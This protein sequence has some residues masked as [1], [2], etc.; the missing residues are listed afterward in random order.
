[1][2]GS[3]MTRSPRNVKLGIPYPGLPVVLDERE[4]AERVRAEPIRANR[5]IDSPAASKVGVGDAL[6]PVFS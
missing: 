3:R 6:E 1:M 4:L 5:S 2:N